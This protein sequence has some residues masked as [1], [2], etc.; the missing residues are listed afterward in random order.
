MPAFGT[1]EYGDIGKTR[2][3]MM[4]AE[5]I[6]RG[7]TITGS[8]PWDIDTRLHGAVLRVRWDEYKMTLAISVVDI[9]WYV[10]SETAWNTIDNMLYG[11]IEQT[12]DMEGVA[13]VGQR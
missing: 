8:N 5:A 4:L 13:D 9:N 10:P 7:A 11:F 1:R 12:K 6:L 3:D 2:I